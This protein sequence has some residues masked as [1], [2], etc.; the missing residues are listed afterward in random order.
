[1]SAEARA[2]RLRTSHATTPSEI[3]SCSSLMR[4]KTLSVPLK[5]L[6]F[7]LAPTSAYPAETYA[8]VA[9]TPLA[10]S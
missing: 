6:A 2:E 3:A 7:W 1:M 4:A 10:T 9:L 5:R 8:F